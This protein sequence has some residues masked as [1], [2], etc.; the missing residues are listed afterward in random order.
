M[1][2]YVYWIHYTHFS[3]LEEGYIGITSNLNKRL[4]KHRQSSQNHMVKSGLTS[5]AIMTCIFQGDK[6][7]CLSLEE[8]L[9]PRTKMGWNIAKGGGIPP[10]FSSHSVESKEKIRQS[11]LDKKTL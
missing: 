5:G 6:E 8:E 11:R 1:K 3:S 7:A 10:K 4:L 9:R 2:Y